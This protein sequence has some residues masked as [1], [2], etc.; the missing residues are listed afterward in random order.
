MTDVDIIE[1]VASLWN[2]KI[3]SYS[4]PGRKTLYM[5]AIGGNSSIPYLTAILPYMGNRR[6]V[7]IVELLDFFESWKD[8]RKKLTDVEVTDI[9]RLIKKGCSQKELAQRYNVNRETI[10]RRTKELV[11]YDFGT[12]DSRP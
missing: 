12:T 5:T 8:P 1:R 11:S 9:Q 3:W 10:Y 2:R 7:K 6:S 4:V